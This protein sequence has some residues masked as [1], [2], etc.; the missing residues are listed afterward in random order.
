MKVA[1]KGL[2]AVV[3]GFNDRMKS[4][5]AYERLTWQGLGNASI[6]VSLILMV[7]YAVA[8]AAYRFGRPE[9]RQSVAFNARGWGLGLDGYAGGCHASLG[10]GYPFFSVSSS[11]FARAH[12]WRSR[13]EGVSRKTYRTSKIRCR[14]L[15]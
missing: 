10:V 9:L 8:I 4:R 5:L 7:V 6:H 3:E 13:A 11:L 15:S 1:Y 12:V 14:S 2:R